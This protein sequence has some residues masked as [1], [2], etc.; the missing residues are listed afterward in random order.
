MP[1]G[2]VPRAS[3]LSGGQRRVYSATELRRHGRKKFTAK[4]KTTTNTVSL[5]RTGT[6]NDS[7]RCVERGALWEQ[8]ENASATNDENT[9]ARDGC[10]EQTDK[11]KERRKKKREKKNTPSQRRRVAAYRRR[12]A[13]RP[14]FI[15][16]FSW[17]RL[18]HETRRI[19]FS[20]FVR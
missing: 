3:S 11:C 4:Q 12:A 8:V 10:D 19:F 16:R 2:R 20:F 15:P 18:V 6:I 1:H 13:H 17:Y 7:P 14:V 9:T 5:L